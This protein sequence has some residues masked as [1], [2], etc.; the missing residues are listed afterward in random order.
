M[1][2]CVSV[3]GANQRW[4]C[5]RR[6]PPKISLK[7]PSR[8][9][10]KRFSTSAGVQLYSTPCR[11]YASLFTDRAI[12][13]RARLGYDQLQVA[14]SVGVMPMVRS[15]QASSGVIFTLDTETGFRDVVIVSSAYGLGEFVVQGVVTPDEWTVFK[16]TLAQGCDAIIGR[17]LGSKEVRLVY[18]DGS[19]A[20]RSEAT[21]AELRRCFSLTDAEVLQLARWAVLIESHY[22]ALAQH[23]RPMDM[24]WAKD[25]ITGDLFIVQARPETVHATKSRTAVAETFRLTGK[26]GTPLVSGQA[27]GEKIGVGRVRVVREVSAL[28]TV[29]AG[30]I[31]VAGNT[32][33]DW[34]PV[35]RR[36]AAIVTDQGGRTAHAAIVSREF[37]LPCLW[38]RG[39]RRPSC[40]AEVTVSCAEGAE[41]H[42]YAGRLPFE[43][44][45]IASPLCQRRAPRSCS[46]SATPA[47]RLGSPACPMRGGTGTHGVHRDQLH[48]HSPDG[49][50]ALSQ[51]H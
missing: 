44:E 33:P 37:G 46:P 28:G 35:M 5:A 24:E 30:E 50:R 29:K 6:Q 2:G 14:L 7:R 8:G 43:V 48:P 11:R 25:G 12:S 42:V 22:L 38:A 47:V 49:A 1:N 39:T 15:D 45:R 36:V 3:W 18:A 20:T 32:D 41:G 16:P 21:P 27:V 51:P 13:Y 4:R 17:R 34:E 23:P 10:R 31:L 26:P 40:D 9:Q 19:R